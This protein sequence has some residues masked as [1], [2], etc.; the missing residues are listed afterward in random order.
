MQTAGQ[1]TAE[2]AVEFRNPALQQIAEHAGEIRGSEICSGYESS[3]CGAGEQSGQS[4]RAKN[5]CNWAD[6]FL[7]A[8]ML[9]DLVVHEV[10]QFVAGGAKV[11]ERATTQGEGPDVFGV[12]I[13]VQAQGAGQ[14]GPLTRSEVLDLGCAGVAANAGEGGCAIV[15]EYAQTGARR[16]DRSS[17]PDG[18]ETVERV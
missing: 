15:P 9:V 3:I 17:G 2:M 14:V 5:R 1:E 8:P 16:N 4:T 12:G 10:R 7:H 6:K 13:V 11:L 18:D